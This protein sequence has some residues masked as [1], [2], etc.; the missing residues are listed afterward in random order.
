VH[1]RSMTLIYDCSS[2]KLKFRGGLT[3][4]Y[5][6]HNRSLGRGNSRLSSLCRV[7]C[8]IYSSV[9]AGKFQAKKLALIAEIVDEIRV[10]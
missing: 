5:Q 3:A 6:R 2:L 7:F 9:G 4:T 8:Q 1:D 10:H